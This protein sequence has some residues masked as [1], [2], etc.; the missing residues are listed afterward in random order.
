M[1]NINLGTYK[2]LCI[3][4]N[5]SYVGSSKNIE[6]RFRIHKSQLNRNVHHNIHLQRAWNKYGKHN[7]VF[8]IIKICQESELKN[9]ENK[10][11]N[12]MDFKNNFNIGKQASG[13][14]NMSNHPNRKIIIERRTKTVNDKMQKMSMED[15][16]IKYGKYGDKNPNW[17]G[18]KTFCECGNRINHN[19]NSCIECVDRSG[20]KNSFFGK[21]HS[22]ETKETLRL[23]KLGKPNRHQNKPLTINGKKYECLSEAEKDTGIVAVTI[24]YRIHSKNPKFSGYIFV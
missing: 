1:N 21:T 16:K 19:S 18:G 10:L 4:D 24:H 11:L 9:E 20:E 3:A 8:E 6:K 13:G 23:L 5:R 14:D 7:F 17:K 2:I 15:R 22:D 12:I